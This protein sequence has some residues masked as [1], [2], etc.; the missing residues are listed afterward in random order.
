[1]KL[2]MKEDEI[3]NVIVGW[4]LKDFVVDRHECN[5]VGKKTTENKKR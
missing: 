1:M 3:K 2:L 5:G 4:G